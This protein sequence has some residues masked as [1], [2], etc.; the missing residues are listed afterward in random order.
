MKIYI[1]SSS[2]FIDDCEILADQLKADLKFTITRKWWDHYIKDEPQF[3]NISDMEF[4][5]N[6]QVEMIRELDFKAVREA[7]MVVIITRD[8]YKLTGAL[9]ELGYA[10]ALGKPVFLLG[11]FKRSAM[12]SGCVMVSNKDQL[13][14]AFKRF[15]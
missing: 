7:D 13:I 14:E 2:R 4:Y 11:Q 15:Q 9:I 5:A 8:E 12:I 3:T 10:L 6:P 1:A